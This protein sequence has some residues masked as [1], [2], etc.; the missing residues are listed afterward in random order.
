[1]TIRQVAV[2]Q[3]W[4][5]S[6]DDDCLAERLRLKSDA[7]APDSAPQTKDMVLLAGPMLH[8]GSYKWSIKL[9]KA[10][11]E[12]EPAAE[13]GQN[14]AQTVTASTSAH[15]KT[16][17]RSTPEIGLGIAS[18]SSDLSVP[19]IQYLYL[20]SGKK[21]SIGYVEPFSVGY[22]FGDVI[23][24]EL[25][26]EKGRLSFS[27]NSENLGVGFYISPITEE[28]YLLCQ[29]NATQLNLAKADRMPTSYC[30]CT[31][32]NDGGS[33][34]ELL[35]KTKS[36]NFS[37][38]RVRRPTKN[39]SNTGEQD[40]SEVVAY[41]GLTDTGGPLFFYLCLRCR[42]L[43][44]ADSRRKG[45]AVGMK[46]CKLCA[47]TCHSHH[48]LALHVSLLQ[49]EVLRQRSCQ[50]LCHTVL[51]ETLL[52]QRLLATGRQK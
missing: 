37:V 38:R 16:S 36:C 29:Q 19:S 32:M 14:H 25:D 4:C 7:A 34:L 41:Q 44:D 24:I 26:L 30:L 42:S 39:G 17:S 52:S 40:S 21:E 6:F 48:R 43:A 10:S 35:S 5:C 49:G 2:W 28:D 11:T 8:Y 9:E 1:M 18:F 31:K 51:E 20:S 15:P 13:L 27:K 3:Y 46:L 50:C 33:R 45:Q 12:E 47:K 22:E 23:E